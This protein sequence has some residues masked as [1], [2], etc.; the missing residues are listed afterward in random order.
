[1]NIVANLNVEL[2]SMRK[3]ITKGKKRNYM[4]WKN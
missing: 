4:C 1:M 3:S 2:K